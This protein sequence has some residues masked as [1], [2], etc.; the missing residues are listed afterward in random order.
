MTDPNPFYFQTYRGHATYSV[1]V[2]DRLSR[3]SGFDLAQCRAALALPGLQKTV[4]VAIERR[5][6]AL[7]REIADK[8]RG[9]AVGPD[10]GR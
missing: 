2:D 6:R 7:Q 1:G 10:R 8:L 9:A 5:Q 3:V 4:R